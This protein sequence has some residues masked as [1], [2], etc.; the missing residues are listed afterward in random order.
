GDRPGNLAVRSDLLDNPDRLTASRT[1]QPGDGSNLLRLAALRDNPLLANGNATF[2]QFYADLTADVGSRVQ[3]L[4]QR[5]S[6]QEV[7]GNRLQAEQQSVS[8]VDPNEELTRLLQFQRSFQY[9]AKFLTVV[10]DTLDDLL[11]L[12]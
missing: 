8:G 4:D 6:A 11:K 5:Q 3:D 9:S 2:S 12:V 10:H 7:V 1:G